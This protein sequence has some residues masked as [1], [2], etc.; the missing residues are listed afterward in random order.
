MRK[1][2]L[3]LIACLSLAIVG[4]AQTKRTAKSV[5]KAKTT[6]PA[7][8]P[9]VPPSANGKFKFDWT[10]GFVNDADGKDFVVISA[11]G[12]SVNDIKS[13]VISTLSD[14]YS[15][16]SKVISTLGDN[17]INLNAHEPKACWY[18]TE[19]FVYD[20]NFNYNIKIECKEGKI[21]V[22]SPSISNIIERIYVGFGN[23]K[24]SNIDLN[25]MYSLLHKLKPEFTQT[26]EDNFNSHITKI[27]TGLSS[28][29]DW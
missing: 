26:L 28:N 3:L 4:D 8:E 15:N 6:T 14:M 21:K 9:V 29:S 13:S 25:K 1:T 17:I 20:Y 16:P 23:Y 2:V 27:I 19:D 18:S 5:R 22:C 7:K 12:K 24:S 10:K 11:P